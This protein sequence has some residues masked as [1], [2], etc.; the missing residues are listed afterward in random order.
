VAGALVTIDIVHYTSAYDEA[1][2]TGIPSASALVPGVFDCAL[3]GHPYLLDR[4]HS[5]VET[6]QAWMRQS[7]QPLIR[8]QSDQ[9]DEPGEQSIS[10]AVQWRK[11]AE[12][13]HKGA[14]QNFLDRKE[15]DR[16][17]FR[18]SKGVNP[19]TRWELTLLDDTEKVDT[20][21][22]GSGSQVIGVGTRAYAASG[23]T[24]NLRTAVDPLSSWSNVTGVPGSGCTSLAT[25]GVNV[26]SAWGANRV[27]VTD[28][29]GSPTTA[30]GYITSGNPVSLLAYLKGRLIGGYQDKLYELTASGA[31]P[32]PFFDHPNANWTWTGLAEGSAFIY[33]AGYAGAFST[34]YKIAVEKETTALVVGTAAMSGLPLGEVVQSIHGSLGFIFLGTNRGV[35][36]C[37]PSDNGDL[38]VGSLIDIGQTVRA[39]ASWDRMI[40]FGWTSFDAVSSGLGRLDPSIINEQDNQQALVPA[41]ASDLMAS[42]T[43]TVS[44]VTTVGTY[45]VFTIDGSGVWRQKV[46]TPVATGTLSTGMITYGLVDT[47]IVTFLDLRHKLLPTGTSISVTLTPDDGTGVLIGTSVTP[48]TIGPGPMNGQNIQAEVFELTFTLNGKVTTTT[49]RPTVR[50]W[51]LRAIPAPTRGSTWSLPL[52]FSETVEA[53]NER[54]YFFDVETEKNFIYDLHRTHRV[55]NLQL[56]GRTYQ[57]VVA[58]Y[59]YLPTR[60]SG[61]ESWSPYVETGIMVV[62]VNEITA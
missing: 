3:D 59:D 51:T 5:D 53:A 38:S 31:L 35:R 23:A 6:I 39:F 41:Y 14:G 24:S 46:G 22:G 48:G 29:V 17:R 40:W 18:S 32:A 9:S 1:F 33:A 25:D 13:W 42:V 21:S 57:V 20:F 26:Y 4:S 56:G 60:T 44:S 12:S 37:V 8:E 58:D 54:Q 30:T 61:N 16:N 28:S 36:F 45:Q 55:V 43:G 19:W 47:K 11:S 62:T 49:A 50:R 15:S 52:I 7:S 10:P 2:S 27:Y 34:V